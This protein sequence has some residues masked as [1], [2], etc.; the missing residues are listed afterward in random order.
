MSF[1]RCAADEP[2][3]T[4]TWNPAALQVGD[5]LDVHDRL[6]EWGVGSV[7]AST[8]THVTIRFKGWSERY[9][10]AIVRECPR[11]AEV[12]HCR[13]VSCAVGRPPPSHLLAARP[14]FTSLHH[15]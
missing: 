10:E 7:A 13:I 5:I 2:T 8:E 12:G 3:A 1:L 9:N 6:G 14:S 11:L 4:A 15:V